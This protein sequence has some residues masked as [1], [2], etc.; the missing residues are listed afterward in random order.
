MNKFMFSTSEMLSECFGFYRYMGDCLRVSTFPLW[1]PYYYFPF[2][3]L[4]FPA[5]FYPFNI[6]GGYISSFLDFNST[7]YLMQI[8]AISHLLLASIF[9]Y[10]F[11]RS[12]EIRQKGALLGAI[13][14]TYSGFVICGAQ[15][16]Y[17]AHTVAWFPLIMLF[18]LKGILKP[19]RNN[20]N[21]VLAGVF[22]AF[23]ILGGFI[24]FTFYMCA[25]LV[26]CAIWF[27]ARLRS[28]FPLKGLLITFTVAVGLACVQL[29]PTFEYFNQSIRKGIGYDLITE[30]GSTP[31]FHFINFFIPHF[32]GGAGTQD[33]AWHILGVGFYVFFYYAGVMSLFLVILGI[34]LKLKI[35]YQ[36]EVYLFLFF[37]AVLS[38]FLIMGNKSAVFGWLYALP[39]L[40]VTRVPTRWALFLDFSL[41]ALAGISFSAL[42]SNLSKDTRQN[43]RIIF[44]KFLKPI[45]LWLPLV[46]A[47]IVCMLLANKH[48]GSIERI[49][50]F[51][52][53]FYIF[54]GFIFVRLFGKFRK[55]YNFI[56]VILV[57]LDLFIANAMTNPA[58]P[59]VY[60]GEKP[61]LNFQDNP[62]VKYLKTDKDI[63]RVSGLLYPINSGQAIQIFTLGYM[64]GFHYVRLG[65]FRGQ[66]NPQGSG[67]LSWFELRGDPLSQFIDFYNVKYLITEYDLSRFWPQK[68]ES[69]AG[70]IGLYRNKNVFPRAYFVSDYEVMP[71]GKGIL[72]RMEQV[73]LRKKVI[74]EEDPGFIGNIYQD[75]PGE[76]KITNYRTQ[77]IELQADVKGDGL[78]VMSEVYYPGW[79]AY[80]DG[81][82]TKI[83][84]ANY[85]FRAISLGPGKHKI[86]FIYS[87]FSVKFGLFIT[88]LTTIVLLVIFL[89]KIWHRK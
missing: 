55:E 3:A 16:I 2:A 51:F 77:E 36:K 47:P 89:F 33:W 7:F 61:S 43:L 84:R 48:I 10:L 49:I 66:T 63:F 24:T 17:Y 73:D 78:L 46:F 14:F 80:V 21:F 87:P 71:D 64:G 50:Y 57:C 60:P 23:A 39:V 18:F 79:Q 83:F 81:E 19:V 6:I 59:A 69:V 34:F 35:N 8:I 27:C 13:I 74:L 28:I 53:F 9:M 58:L 29:T 38:L 5:V 22:L 72:K 76:V 30:W 62:L 37:L 26:F 52:I 1:D 45:A 32:F 54:I 44:R 82:K 41:A 12:F 4:I 70:F 56:F 75:T 40:P 25:V 20:L 85:V 11:L 42:S 31:A 65:D 15:S 86:K 67:S 88:L 68:Y